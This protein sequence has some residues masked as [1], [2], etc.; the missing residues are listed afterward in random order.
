MTFDR[1]QWRSGNVRVLTIAQKCFL[2]TYTRFIHILEE[3]GSQ[4]SFSYVWIRFTLIP[5]QY[6]TVGTVF[7][8]LFYN[9]KMLFSILMLIDTLWFIFFF[10]REFF[11][12]V[13]YGIIIMKPEKFNTIKCD[14][15]HYFTSSSRNNN[16][17]NKIM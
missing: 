7:I 1:R 14:L 17:V 9:R 5:I 15:C 12:L 3:N 13:C 2:G 11:V 6:I 8:G 16:M 4:Y 10:K